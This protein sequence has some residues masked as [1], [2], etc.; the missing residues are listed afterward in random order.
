M[1]S[2]DGVFIN[3]ARLNL[4]KYASKPHLAKALFQY[5]YYHENDVKKVKESKFINYVKFA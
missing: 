1:L 5:I 3:L 2:S 4:S